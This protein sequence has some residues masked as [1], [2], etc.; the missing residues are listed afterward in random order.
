VESTADRIRLAPGVVDLD[1]DQFREWTETGDWDSAARLVRGEF[2]EDFEIAGAEGWQEW[3]AAERIF[4]RGIGCDALLRSAQLRY[5]R[6]VASEAIALAERAVKLR[7]EWDATICMLMRSL[8]LDGNASSA[9]AH[10]EAF[11]ARQSEAGTE[12]E[13]ATLELAARILRGTTASL[14]HNA[15]ENPAARLRTPLLA[16]ERPLTDLLATISRAAGA[17][18]SALCLIEG[19]VGSGKTRLLEEVVTHARLDG[20]TVALARA[21][22]GDASVAWSGVAGLS[23]GGL[24]DAPGVIGAS[25]AALGG[26]AATD[27]VWSERFHSATNEP[28]SPRRAFAE[29]VRTVAEEHPLLLAVDDAEALDPESVEALGAVLRDL[30]SATVVVVLAL[31]AGHHRPDLDQLQSRIGRELEGVVVQLNPLPD[32]AIRCLAAA[33]VSGYDDDQ[34]DRLAR[35]VVADSSGSPLFATELLRGIAAGL[36]LDRVAQ[37]WPA[38][39]RTLDQPFPTEFPPAL[40][41]SVRLNFQ[42][43]GED[44]RTV[45]TAIAAIGSRC[46][47]SDVSRVTGL[48]ADRTAAALDHLEM[49]RWLISDARGYTFAAGL[50]GQVILREMLTPGQRRRFQT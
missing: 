10:F 43:L 6:G 31:G 38:P 16:R 8:A 28:L 27:P 3:C 29:V 5:D 30:R 37:P 46:A 20:F 47:D 45:L 50:V 7:P 4:W 14:R 24:V 42:R 39:A 26:M 17:R 18:H 35:R 1:L 12:P 49:H 21:V 40:V 2:L 33:M 19:A 15:A 13:P 25:A 36:D 48:D 23:R 11:A 44:A 32:E 9:L 34:L 22:P 41:A